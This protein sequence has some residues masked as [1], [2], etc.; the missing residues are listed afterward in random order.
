VH[1]LAH[2]EGDAFGDH[3]EAAA[4]RRQI[5]VVERLGVAGFKG[6]RFLKMSS[7]FVRTGADAQY[8]ILG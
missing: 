3:G 6:K 2:L 1:E 5:D 7:E 8:G 4:Y